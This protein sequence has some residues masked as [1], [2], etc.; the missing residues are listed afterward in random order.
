[1][2]PL[3]APPITQSAAHS[4]L[5]KEQH[6]TSGMIKYKLEQLFPLTAGQQ[7]KFTKVEMG[8][9][10]SQKAQLNNTSF[11]AMQWYI[12]LPSC[13]LPC[14]HLAAVCHENTSL[15]SLLLPFLPCCSNESM[16]GS[17]LH[18][19][20]TYSAKLKAALLLW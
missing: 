16:S 18:L 4:A 17:L 10:C 8:F 13:F 6:I 2:E 7:P 9:W 19:L 5:S 20:L 14:F 1:M 12:L 3:Q 15:L 11:H